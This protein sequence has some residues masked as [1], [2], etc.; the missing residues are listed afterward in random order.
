LE[1]CF[2]LIDLHTTKQ[3][4]PVYPKWTTRI[5]ESRST[6][7]NFVERRNEVG[8]I[9]VGL[10]MSFVETT[11]SCHRCIMDIV[12]LIKTAKIGRERK[13]AQVDTCAAFGAALYDVLAENGFSPSLVTACY[14]GVSVD[15]TWYHQV[16]EVEGKM[17]DSLGEFSTDIVRAR[18]KIHPKVDYQ[19]AYTPERR[20]GCY[21]DDDFQ[22]V[23]EFLLKELRKAAKKLQPVEDVTPAFGMR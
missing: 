18:L 14:R 20:E 15:R 23:Y 22:L 2:Q 19:L 10:Q 16:V 21:D 11:N 6:N 12:E 8:P 1:N 7:N 3:G 17:Y 9:V 13:D 4:F 5:F